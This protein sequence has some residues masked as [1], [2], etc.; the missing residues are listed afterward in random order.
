M[1]P[2]PT[3]RP[4]DD[5]TAELTGL[6]GST[7]PVVRTREAYRPLA[8]WI[9]GGVYDD[10]LVGLGDGMAVGLEVGLGQSDSDTVFRR[11]WSAR[12]LAECIERDNVAPR[13]SAAQI[14]RWGDAIATW[15]VRERDLRGHVPGKGPAVT[16][17][18]GAD[19]LAALAR[20]PHFGAP[21]LTVL[22]DVMADRLLLPTGVRLVAGEPDRLAHAT[23]ALLARDLVP[24]SILEP[25][26]ARLANGAVA[27]D[28]EGAVA[29]R[30]FNTQAYLRALY[31]QVAHGPVRPGVR[32]DL[33][34]ILVEALR[35]TTPELRA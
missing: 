18:H 28:P 33:L 11:S 3:D 23:V 6:L 31:L 7:D 30:A 1:P 26:V 9:R 27:I 21:E 35:E 13:A 24:L 2:L 34:L 17:S 19:A 10:V 29:C 15:L 14:L 25:W 22:L 5:V 32:P 16:V 8:T 12:V 4:L 20:S